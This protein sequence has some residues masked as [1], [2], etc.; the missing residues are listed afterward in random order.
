[1]VQRVETKLYVV[2]QGANRKRGQE[3]LTVYSREE[4]QHGEAQSKALSTGW[5]RPK[6]KAYTMHANFLFQYFLYV[7]VQ[8]FG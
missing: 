6:W 4:L 2:N 5:G 1:M 7:L 8:D 3:V